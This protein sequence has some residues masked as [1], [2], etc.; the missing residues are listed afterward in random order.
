MALGHKTAAGA[1]ARRTARLPAKVA[2]IGPDPA[3][4]HAASRDTNATAE[5]RDDMAEA[6]LPADPGDPDALPAA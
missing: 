3:R 4:L 5:R 1:K 2:E 6:A